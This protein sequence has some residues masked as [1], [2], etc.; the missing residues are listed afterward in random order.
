MSSKKYLP[1]YRALKVIGS[2]QKRAPG[3]YLTLISTLKDGFIPN[4]IIPVDAAGLETNDDNLPQ[5][6]DS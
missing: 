6:Y 3:A 1:S 4:E 2:F 5:I